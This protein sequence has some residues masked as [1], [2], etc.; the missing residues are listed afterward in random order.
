VL[1]SSEALEAARPITGFRRTGSEPER[2]TPARLRVLD[3][4]GDGEVWP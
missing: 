2:L 3:C 1:R 4:L